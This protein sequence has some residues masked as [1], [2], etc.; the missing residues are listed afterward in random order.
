MSRRAQRE[1][2]QDQFTGLV[3]HAYDNG[4]RFFETAGSYGEM[5]K[6]LGVALKG[7]Q[8]EGV[9]QQAKIDELRKLAK[10]DCFDVML[11]H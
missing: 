4:I 9:D 10:T 8:C 5:H 1:P 2:V 6:M 11:L 7:V 3:R